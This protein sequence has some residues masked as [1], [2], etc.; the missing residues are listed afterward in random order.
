MFRPF[1]VDGVALL[2]V[3]PG[4]SLAEGSAAIGRLAPGARFPHHRH[5]GEE[6]TLVLEGGLRDEDGREV[7]RGEEL[8]KAA[9]T[10]HDFVVVGH[11]V[12]V[13]AVLAREGVVFG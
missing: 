8:F 10:S 2:L 12:C 3:A 7:W 4:P 11:E 1:G 5:L 13:A 6:T 9:G